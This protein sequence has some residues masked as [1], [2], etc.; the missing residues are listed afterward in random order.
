MT[1]KKQNL[2]LAV[3][4]LLVSGLIASAQP[5]RQYITV[6]AEPDHA[7]WI[8]RCGE[9]ATFTL[10]ALK[11][12]ARMPLTEIE[13]SF[14]PEKLPAEKSGRV[15]T[16]KDG[17]AKITVPGRKEPG[18]TTVSVKVSHDGKT[19]SGQTNIGF[20]PYSIRPTTTLPEDFSAFWEKE[21]AAAAKV[22]MLVRERYC[23]EESD[24][25]VDVYYVR[26]QSWRE[27][28]YVY[29][30]LTVPK[31]P[32]PKPAIL[33]LPGAAVRSFSGPNP[34]AYEG[35]VVL[36]IGVHGIPVDQDPEIY[37]QLERGSMSGYVLKGLESK[38]TYYYKRTYLG[39]VRA[40]DYLC[41][42]EDVDTKRIATYGGSQ[43]GMLSIVTASLDGR[44][45]A[46]FSYYPA[47]CDVTGYYCGRSGG[48]PHLF[49]NPD[50]PLIKEKVQASKYY[51]VVNFARFLKAPGF[52]AWGFND[53]VCCPSSTFSA[54]NVIPAEKTLVIAKDTGH[55]L[56]PWQSEKALEWLKRQFGMQ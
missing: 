50:E 35:F 39:C 4:S 54:Y 41:S 37:R 33:R 18:F 38:E 46:L 51:D 10:Y 53:I 34:L 23:P 19:Y 20:D 13:Y 27:G 44:I 11:E 48:W 40:V 36:E 6:V 43:G 47:F 32:G 7:D 49:T 55:W 24:D 14:G 3:C 26:I 29:G 42:R 9:K 28:N 31:T 16:G 8:Y 56:Y 17:F 15:T 52:Y 5:A 30:V 45:S 21:K 25:R 1:M 2:F 12:N 22:P